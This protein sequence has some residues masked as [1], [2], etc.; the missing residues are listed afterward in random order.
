MPSANARLEELAWGA[1]ASEPVC[2]SEQRKRP[3][4]PSRTCFCTLD[5]NLLHT[6]VFFHFFG[7][8]NLAGTHTIKWVNLKHRV[9][10][11]KIENENSAFLYFWQKPTRLSLEELR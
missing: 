9:I 1:G 3:A 6:Y 8:L 7:N 10:S 2:T 5:N 4:R 11:H